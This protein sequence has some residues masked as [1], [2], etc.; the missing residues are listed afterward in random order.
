[1]RRSSKVAGRAKVMVIV[2]L[3][4][5]A[6][7]AW[8]W[9]SRQPTAPGAGTARPG[10]AASAPVSAAPAP[11]SASQVERGIDRAREAVQKDP[12]DASQWAMLAHSHEMLGRFDEAIKAYAR[13]IEL[14]P[15]D[16]QALADYADALGVTQRGSLLGE[17]AK[18][19]ARAL[20]ADAKNLKALV[21]AGK[22]A[23][24]RKRYTEAVALWERALPLSQDPAVRRPVETSIAEARALAN[25]QAAAQ[26]A[27]AASGA[28][29]FVTGRV[30]VADSLK[31][32]IGPDDTV[33]VLARPADGKS[34]MPIALLRKQGRDLPL[35]FALDDSLAMVP[36]ARLSQ[37]GQVLL[38]VRVSKRGDAIPASGDL[39]G[40][41]GPVAVGATGLKL[42][43]SR[44]RP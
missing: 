19:I 29:G 31:G 34:R 24:E 8:W 17:P 26:P 4:L 16:A 13:L 25:P 35:D 32:R 42:E 28:L 14:R 7:L 1:M 40:E 37:Q 2:G 21:L 6:S 44:A 41:L 9:T 20:A 12:K 10:A 18:L 11:L 23:F 33:F 39:E 27:S 36:Q 5:A 30:T 38:G 15:Q 3:V 22:E 43:I